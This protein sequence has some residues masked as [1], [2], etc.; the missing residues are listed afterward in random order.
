V[1]KNYVSNDGKQF[2]SARE[3]DVPFEPTAADSLILADKSIFR[4][5]ELDGGLHSPR[6]SYFHKSVGGYSAVRP[7]RFEE[8]YTHLIEKS[9]SS[10]GDNVDPKTLA[11][12]KSIP[13]LDAFNIKYLIIGTEQGDIPVT[14]PFHNGNAWFVTKIQTVNSADEELKTLGKIDTKEIAVRQKGKDE[15]SF[16]VSLPFI[17]DSLA[18]IKLD[19][20]KPNH[21]VYT[22][23]N[24]NNGFAVFSEIY[25]KDGW[26][27]TID[28]KET[29][30]YKVDYTLRGM[31]IPKGNHKIEFKFEPQVVKTGSTIA[32]ISSILMLLVVI[33][34]VYFEQKGKKTE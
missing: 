20:Y 2:R 4:V 7:R 34:V 16:E 19:T 17:K 28:G 9:M 22:S 14:N 1:D 13:V 23:N 6:S 33:G 29:E 25:Y 21:L 8:V 27:A 24:N 31:Y 18:S 15:K 5:Y 30:I 11:L 3:V 10:L 26:K 12:T 32:L